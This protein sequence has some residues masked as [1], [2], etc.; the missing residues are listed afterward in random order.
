MEGVACN[1]KD[2]MTKILHIRVKSNIKIYWTSN[3]ILGVLIRKGFQLINLRL[4]VNHLEKEI[5]IIYEFLW[6][7][8][9]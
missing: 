4:V 2:K 1:P 5:S 9:T 8:K 3:A 6:S 7:N